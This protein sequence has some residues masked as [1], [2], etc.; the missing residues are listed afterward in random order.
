MAIILKT[1]GIRSTP[2][3]LRREV[4]SSFDITSESEEVDNLFLQLAVM[5]K[6]KKKKER[7]INY[8]AQEFFRKREEKEAF[9]NLKRNET[10]R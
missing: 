7:K 8:W 9:S 2:K 1:S 4:P 6:M 5:F 3:G 10:G